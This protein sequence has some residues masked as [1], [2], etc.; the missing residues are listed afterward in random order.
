LKSENDALKLKIA[1]L[2]VNPI[3]QKG[4]E[5]INNNSTGS[6]TDTS[7][8][9]TL[10]KENERLTKEIEA[11]KNKPPT[12]NPISNNPDTNATITKLQK[13]LAEELAKN[14]N[15]QQQVNKKPVATAGI[16]IGTNTGTNTAIN[17]NNN[18]N[19]N[20]NNNNTGINNNNN[21]NQPK[22]NN[23]KNTFTDFVIGHHTP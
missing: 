21:N 20:A 8:F 7:N 14:A 2:N 4:N 6:N 10:K 23:S 3:P 16:S 5:K 22:P 13:Q 1:E 19:N 18:A 17:N 15:L 12:N 11:L 9:Y